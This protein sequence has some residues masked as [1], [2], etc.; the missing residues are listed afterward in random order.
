MKFRRCGLT[1][2]LA[3]AALLRAAEPEIEFAG[4]ITAE[5]KTRIALT[6]K[7]KKTTTWVQPGE[8]FNG[9][10]VA[11]YEAKE[12]AVYLKKGGQETRL[13]LVASRTTESKPAAAEEVFVPAAQASAI[14]TSIR[15]NLRQLAN[16]ARQYQLERGVTSVGYADLVGPD[17]L[18]KELKPIAGENYTTLNFSPN[19][20]TVSVSTSGGAIVSYDLPP[21]NAAA[22]APLPVPA[23]TPPAS[24]PPASP[25]KQ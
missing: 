19:V 11:R 23:A 14:A 20:T 15:S 8:T 24:T 3:L 25:R 12:E 18:V 5:G 9:Y 7:S 2:F 13:G 16:A 1:G 22:P 21:A 10:T 6:D 4:I 17:K